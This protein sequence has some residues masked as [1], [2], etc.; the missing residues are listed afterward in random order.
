VKNNRSLRNDKRVEE[1]IN[2]EYDEQEADDEIDEESDA[3][4]ETQTTQRNAVKKD[5]LLRAQRMRMINQQ[6]D[7]HRIRC[8]QQS[9]KLYPAYHLPTRFVI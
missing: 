1:S 3:P 5:A 7:P 8:F 2:K 6:Q 4:A 9:P